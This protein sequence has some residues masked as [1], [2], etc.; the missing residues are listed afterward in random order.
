MCSHALSAFALLS[1]SSLLLLPRIHQDSKD[2]PKNTLN[3]SGAARAHQY[4]SRLLIISV[5]I[6]DERLSRSSTALIIIGEPVYSYPY[7]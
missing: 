2:D 3:H 7:V 5:I 6:I 1:K 4:P